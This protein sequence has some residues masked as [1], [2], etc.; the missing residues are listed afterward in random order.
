MRARLV[1]T[2]LKQKASQMK[3]YVKKS[4]GLFTA[5]VHEYYPE[6]QVT[7]VHYTSKQHES[8]EAAVGEVVVFMLSLGVIA[9]SLDFSENKT[10]LCRKAT[11]TVQRA[12]RDL[13]N[14]ARYHEV[15]LFD[16][17][18]KNTV[19]AKLEIGT[20]NDIGFSIGF[21][22]YG[23]QD[24]TEDESTVAVVTHYRGKLSMDVHA[25][26]NSEQPTHEIDFAEAK[27]DRFVD[28]F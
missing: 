14:Y 10:K 8:A 19:I 2:N 25:D 12:H 1:L 18:T 27:L 15:P 24:V 7:Y 5:A 4:N 16:P 9:F 17:E 21:V 13:V 20:P 28:D 11:K 23:S 26:I 22:G 3:V 6:N